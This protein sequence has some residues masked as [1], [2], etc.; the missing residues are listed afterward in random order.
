[1]TTLVMKFGGSSVG[2]TTAL[3]QVLSIV[4]YEN[5][6][7][8]RLILVVSALDGVTDALIEAAHLAQ[9]GNQ[10]GYRR[11]I[12]NLRTRHLALIE[13]LPLGTTERTALQADIDRLLFD[14]LDIYQTMAQTPADTVV[15][16]KVDATIGVGE[17]LAARIIA[18]L[19]RQNDLRSVAIDATTLMVTNEA[20][21]NAIPNIHLTRELVLNNLLPMLDRNIIPVVTGFIGA[22]PKG[23]PTTMGRG[24]SDL[25][26]SI[27]GVCAKAD[28]V[29]IWTAVD[30]MMTADP[31]EVPGARVI[32]TLS[33]QEVAELAY[34]GARILHARMVAPLSQERIPL[35]VKNVYKPQQA[36]TLI[37]NIPSN[38][39]RTLKAVTSISGLGLLANRSGSLSP[40]SLLVDETLLATTHTQAE[41]MISSQSSSSSFV[42]FLIPT[43]A[44]PDAVH[45]AKQLLEEKLRENPESEFWTVNP[46]SIITAISEKVDEWP[47]LTASVLQTIGKTR[48]LEMTQGPS[49]CTLSLIVEP[50]DSEDILLLIHQL[51]INS[52]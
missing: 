43:S 50:Q 26:A 39:S 47:E 7:W 11:I 9:L 10:R 46:V 25:T 42:C 30:G 22:T 15:P 3:T 18:A 1:M 34:F 20:F 24:G 29:W 37:H 28:E 5:E 23:I 17:R 38:R 31:R 6:Q 13:E 32:P 44:G 2:T 4:L 21:G 36:G 41:V 51:I 8:D 35:R 27:L 49:H 33:Y 40:I 16:D 48:I 52:G 12:A 19:L 14:L 45:G